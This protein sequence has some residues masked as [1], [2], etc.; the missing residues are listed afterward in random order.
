VY[1]Q[2]DLASFLY[3]ESRHASLQHPGVHVKSIKATLTILYCRQLYQPSIQ[4][5]Y[6]TASGKG[7]SIC[8]CRFS[9]AQE[10]A[11]PK[12]SDSCNVERLSC[13]NADAGMLKRQPEIER[14]AKECR[15]LLPADETSG[16]L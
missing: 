11:M 2:L 9:R 6:H 8:I 5:E 4:P 12:Q 1:I 10:Q 7:N 16:H 13:R 3:N 15:Q 14:S